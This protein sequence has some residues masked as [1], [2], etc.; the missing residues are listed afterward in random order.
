MRKHLILILYM[1][2]LLLGIFL[3]CDG[4]SALSLSLGSYGV[5]LFTFCCYA[6]VGGMQF[7][8]AKKVNY[9]LV[10]FFMAFSVIMYGPYN[11][12]IFAIP[13]SALY[14]WLHLYHIRKNEIKNSTDRANQILVS[15]IFRTIDIS[16]LG[17]LFALWSKK[18]LALDFSLMELFFVAGAAFIAGASNLLSVMIIRLRFSKVIGLLPLSM[19]FWTLMTL[20]GYLAAYFM[21]LSLLFPVIIMF[22]LVIVANYS[23]FLLSDKR[24]NL[25]WLN[26]RMEVL[27]RINEIGL[28]NKDTITMLQIIQLEFSSRGKCEDLTILEKGDVRFKFVFNPSGFELN[29]EMGAFKKDLLPENIFRNYKF[30]K[31]TLKSVSSKNRFY[32]LILGGHDPIP[33]HSEFNS[34]AETIVLMFERN[35]MIQ[36]LDEYNG[37]LKEMNAK[38]VN[39]KKLNERNAVL[40]DDK[41]RNSLTSIYGYATLF[42]TGKLGPVTAKQKKVL[43]NMEEKV[44]NILLRVGILRDFI[45]DDHIK[46][47]FSSFDY[48]EVLKE[49]DLDEDQIKVTGAH[50]FFGDVDKLRFVILNIEAYILGHGGKIKGIE[51]HGENHITLIRIINDTVNDLADVIDRNDVD[52]ILVGEILNTKGLNVSVELKKTK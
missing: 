3:F 11:T 37:Q 16:V 21:S 25:N 45:T 9:S 36:E 40:I 6:L 47:N 4:S 20:S 1:V 41:I 43:F 26:E 2:V 12:L 44:R 29:P 31:Y 48:T 49:I 39:Q 38:V 28:K 17:I 19:L 10:H 24:D 51:L 15:V 14:K 50:N 46:L 27:N 32:L 13:F 52:S 30:P 18:G 42:S 34:V 5:L 23:L 33:G 35:K 8:V 7:S 22:A